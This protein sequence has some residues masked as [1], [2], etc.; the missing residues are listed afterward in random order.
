MANRFPL[1]IDT[2]NDNKIKELPDGDNLN[3]EGSS[4]VNVENIHSTGTID[5]VS[6]LISGQPLQAQTFLDLS[7]TPLSFEGNANFLLKVNNDETGIEFASFGDFGNITVDNILLKGNINVD[8]NNTRSIGSETQKLSEIWST[9]IRAS[10]KSYSGEVVF[11][12][13][14]GLINYAAIQNTPTNLSDFTNDLN[15]I[16]Q[17]NLQSIVQQQ[18][19]NEEIKINVIRG[20]DSAV[21]LDTATNS[22]FSSISTSDLIQ[23]N[24]ST[25]EP[26]QSEGT[27][28]LA[29]G[30]GWNPLN[31]GEQSLVIYLNGQWKSIATGS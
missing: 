20:Q 2:Q 13:N 10:L 23:L 9:E 17:E 1:I 4:I 3:L 27:I 30:I 31:N 12:A 19:D 25:S 7:D 28:A 5:A 29:D 14:T 24:F 11:D 6:V 26:Q 18:L 15:F 16:P 8:S 21:M 22:L